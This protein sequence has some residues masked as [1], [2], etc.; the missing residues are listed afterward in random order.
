M[1]AFILML[2]LILLTGFLK[3]DFCS[4]Q[5]MKAY[6]LEGLLKPDKHRVPFC[7]E[8]QQNCCTEQD[9]VSV[10]DKYYDVLLPK[11]EELKEQFNNQVKHL[12]KLHERIIRLEQ[13]DDYIGEQRG[14]CQNT[15][16]N[17]TDFPFQSMTHSLREGFHISQDIFE[18]IHESFLCVFCDFEL[19]KNIILETMQIGQDGAVCLE[20]LSKNTDFMLTSN[21]KL[22][23]FYKSVQNYLDCQ[24]IRGRFNFP[25]LFGLMADMQE[26]VTECYKKFDPAV[27]SDSCRNVCGHF[28]LGAI[29][30]I[31]EGNVYFM[32][33]ATTY[34][35]NIITLIETKNNNTAFNP[36]NALNELNEPIH[37]I[38]F[39]QIPDKRQRRMDAFR[40][41]P[42]RHVGDIWGGQGVVRNDLRPYDENPDVED[43]NSLDPNSSFQMNL[44]LQQQQEQQQRLQEQQANNQQQT[45]RKR[46]NLKNNKK[47]QVFLKKNG[48][49]LKMKKKSRKAALIQKNKQPKKLKVSQ[50]KAKKAQLKNNLKNTSRK[51][52][53]KAKKSKKNKLAASRKLID[54]DEST[55][56]TD[57]ISIKA[58]FENEKTKLSQKPKTKVV[59][60]KVQKSEKVKKSRKLNNKSEIEENKEQLIA[61]TRRQTNIKKVTLKQ[62]AVLNNQ[63]VKKLIKQES[64]EETDIPQAYEQPEVQTIQSKKRKLIQKNII[65]KTV[66]VKPKVEINQNPKS[67]IETPKTTK[68]AK[69]LRVINSNENEEISKKMEI[70]P[71]KTTSRKMKQTPILLQNESQPNIKEEESKLLQEMN[72]LFAKKLSKILKNKKKQ[73][74]SGKTLKNLRI[75]EE[76][77]ENEKKIKR[78]LK[79]RR[80]L[81]ESSS[82]GSS[83][84]KMTPEE[85]KKQRILKHYYEYFNSLK[86]LQ[87]TT[88]NEIFKKDN[89]EYDIPL[90]KRILL[91]NQ[92]LN[93]DV[94]AASVD[95]EMTRHQLEVLLQARANLDEYDEE[96]EILL[97]TNFHSFGTRIFIELN[98]D[99]TSLINPDFTSQD[100]IE[101]MN[102]EVEYE[103]EEKFHQIDHSFYDD[104]F[105][106]RMLHKSIDPL[107]KPLDDIKISEIERHQTDHSKEGYKDINPK[108][109]FD[110][111]SLSGEK[112]YKK[113]RLR[114]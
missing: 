70:N 94:H 25:F 85:R 98:K 104:S 30:P 15:L 46:R 13:K 31:F 100:D 39:F 72:T 50:N 111:H 55:V 113:H 42:N 26:D 62:N 96:M 34:F 38:R 21:V 106:M 14:F 101:I 95:F 22:V 63:H 82:G 75:L 114:I 41:L 37:G 40:D 107:I 88:S 103:E 35:D 7:P 36:I 91:L 73:Q 80:I 90:F 24:L 11:M 57:K 2:F 89:N 27:M 6:S 10:Y 5:L 43:E 112:S 9:I 102:L 84:G 65:K 52:K 79:G 16:K 4:T 68:R 12:E 51:T 105:I 99:F 29:S 53:V 28:R 1:K 110:S 69:K 86:F 54:E 71:L 77:F 92:G 67:P 56:Q 87:N 64:V 19:Q 109:W 78:I 58:D 81:A 20:V 49:K 83:G 18:S 59:L 47:W 45:P 3:A 61:N 74:L 48:K 66:Q 97:K 32:D 108:Y 93:T 33:E 76:N 60:E 17:F 8:I 44:R 23:N